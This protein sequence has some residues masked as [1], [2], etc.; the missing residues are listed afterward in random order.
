MTYQSTTPT[1]ESWKAMKQRCNNPKNASAANY[2][3]RGITYDPRWGIFELFL[4]DMGE[5]PAGMT[6]DRK[7]SNENYCKDNCRWA[8]FTE[9]AQNK[10]QGQ[11]RVDNKSGLPGVTWYPQRGY[12]QVHHKSKGVGTFYNLLDAAAAKFRSQRG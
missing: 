6:L 7:D 11:L 10:R 3:K 4:E 9:Q 2:S 12:W 8:T 1:Y 5:R